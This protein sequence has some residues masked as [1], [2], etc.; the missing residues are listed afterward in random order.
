VTRRPLDAATA[1]VAVVVALAGIALASQS[2]AFGALLLVAI[3]LLVRTEWWMPG[4][5]GLAL[6]AVTPLYAAVGREGSTDVLATLVVLLATISLVHLI[7]LERKR[8]RSA[9]R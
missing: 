6:L 9:V 2:F 4:V 5:A 1:P 8:I 3:P 7:V